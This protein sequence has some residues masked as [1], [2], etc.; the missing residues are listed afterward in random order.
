MTDMRGD[1]IISP[2]LLSTRSNRQAITPGMMRENTHTINFLVAII[3]APATDASHEGGGFIIVDHPATT[4]DWRAAWLK[5]NK[6]M[7]GLCCEQ[8]DC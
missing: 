6:M 2:L 3:R 8:F 1:T 4:W 7:T 5:R